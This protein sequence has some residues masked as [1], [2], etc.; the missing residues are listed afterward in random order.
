MTHLC[1][2]QV[3]CGN[4]N[5][6]KENQDLAFWNFDLFWTIS[7]SKLSSFF[8][9]MINS[10]KQLTTLL[11]MGRRMPICQNIVRGRRD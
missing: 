5:G 4:T 1:W 11:V 2:T 6:P 10:G 7:N 8:F 9:V 3:Q